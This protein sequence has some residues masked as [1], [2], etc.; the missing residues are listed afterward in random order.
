MLNSNNNTEINEIYANVVSILIN[1]EKLFVARHNNTLYR[2]W[3]NR[4][5]NILKKDAVETN[6]IGKPAGNMA[7]H[8]QAL[9]LVYNKQRSGMLHKKGLGSV[10]N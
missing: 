7:S 3:W 2:F 8:V 5:F 10:S 9:F 4:E 6:K 1:A